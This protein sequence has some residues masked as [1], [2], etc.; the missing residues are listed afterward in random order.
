MLR[1][2][3]STLAPLGLVVGKDELG[4]RHIAVLDSGIDTGMCEGDACN[5]IANREQ[6]C[7][8]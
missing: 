5:F 3:P 8:V 7:T 2:D 6:V 4:D 1:Y